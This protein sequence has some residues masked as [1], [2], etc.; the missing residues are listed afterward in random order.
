[1]IKMTEKY[2]RE[3]LERK[4]KIWSRSSFASL[5]AIATGM[6]IVFYSTIAPTINPI[7]KPGIV[8][9]YEQGQEILETLNHLKTKSKN[10]VGKLDCPE[11]V[12]GLT[13]II[14]KFD[15]YRTSLKNE[16]NEIEEKDTN[17]KN[18][19]KE[20]KKMKKKFGI[21]QLT[22][23]S[24]TVLSLLGGLFACSKSIEYENKLKK[25]KISS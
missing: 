14:T 17:F 13:N 16:L 22:G 25:Y 5:G 23:L 11:G 20:R 21:Y 10:Q 4:I 2:S 1:M 15:D 24:M 18:Y 12:E 19:Q 7:T 8:Q 9:E 6:G 3:V